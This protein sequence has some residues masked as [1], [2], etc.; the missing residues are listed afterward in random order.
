MQ[1][2]KESKKTMKQLIQNTIFL[3]IASLFLFNNALLDTNYISL[4]LF[5]F[6]VFLYALYYIKKPH[7]G[8]KGIIIWFTVFITF[9]LMSAMWAISP[10][11]VFHKTLQLVINLALVV[12][13][14]GT[15]EDKD[16]LQRIYSFFSTSGVLLSFILFFTSSYGEATRYSRLGSQIGNTNVIGYNILCSAICSFILYKKTKRKKY[17]IFILINILAIVFAG[18]RKTILAIPIM[19][20][21]YFVFQKKARIREKIKEVAIALLALI[22]LGVLVF[23]NPYIYNIVGVRLVDMVDFI[24]G[25]SVSDH[26][27]NERSDMISIGLSWTEESPVIGH[28]LDN[29]VV[30]YQ[31]KYGLDLYA[32]NNYIELL[33]DLGVVGLIIYYA[34]SFYM[35]ASYLKLRKSG[36]AADGLLL[37]F[38][39]A[40]L[41]MDYAK[42]S[43]GERIPIM[44]TTITYLNLKNSSKGESL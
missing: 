36:D 6:I 13:L 24:N 32:H 14:T 3:Y 42:V 26:S 17:I 39:V 21:V 29:Y 27:I 28:G 12:I 41:V 2:I 10:A 15:V 33:V 11:N 8:P 19:I 31:K 30:M 25:D 1:S 23:C 7:S 16:D 35:I 38:L 34:F 20:V 37:A 22:A 9:G 4:V 40:T 18:S 43:Y 5:I 44:M